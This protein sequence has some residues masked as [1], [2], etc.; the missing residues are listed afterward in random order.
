MMKYAHICQPMRSFR[1]GAFIFPTKFICTAE[2]SKV[3]I[4]TPSSRKE[5]E[6]ED[7]WTTLQTNLVRRLQTLKIPSICEARQCHPILLIPGGSVD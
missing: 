1:L 4:G 3:K 6:V 7:D 2:D 5:L